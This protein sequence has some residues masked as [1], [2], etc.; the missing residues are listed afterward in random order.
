MLFYW[1]IF[2][3]TALPLLTKLQV[4]VVNIKLQ[5]FIEGVRVDDG[6]PGDR[7]GVGRLLRPLL[8]HAD[9]LR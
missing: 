4:H 9:L 2:L 6:H 5:L 8:L 7:A 1:L 3:P